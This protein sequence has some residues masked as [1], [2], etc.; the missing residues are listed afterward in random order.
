MN[1]TTTASS[2]GSF[3]TYTSTTTAYPSFTYQNI[4]DAM[5]QLH[6]ASYSVGN[7]IDSFAAQIEALQRL[8]GNNFES[9][10]YDDWDD[11]EESE[12]LTEFLDQFAIK[13]E[14]EVS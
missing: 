10:L 4:I 3:V 7:A 14:L 12:E 6:R 2:T 13:K 9:F 8:S 5:Q 1:Y 11:E